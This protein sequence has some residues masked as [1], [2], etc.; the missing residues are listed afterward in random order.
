MLASTGFEGRKFCGFLH[1]VFH[2]Q[3]SLERDI[4]IYV[5][6][7]DRIQNHIGVEGRIFSGFYHEMFHGKIYR[8]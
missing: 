4:Y 7:E 3:I 6:I 1:D 5:Y 8:R 2:G